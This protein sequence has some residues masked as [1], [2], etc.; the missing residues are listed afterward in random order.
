MIWRKKLGRA[1]Q[2]FGFYP[3]ASLHTPQNKTLLV[4][5]YFWVFIEY[6]LG[7]CFSPISHTKNCK[8]ETNYRLNPTV[9]RKTGVKRKKGENCYLWIFWPRNML[10]LKLDKYIKWFYEGCFHCVKAV[11]PKHCSGTILPKQ[12][13]GALT[14]LKF[15][16]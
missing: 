14:K 8:K 7:I 15:Y 10:F 16:N 2:Y 5:Q 3:R 12:Y 6:A 1:K 9:L 11:V 13:W 4:G